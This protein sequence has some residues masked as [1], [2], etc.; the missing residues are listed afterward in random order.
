MKMNKVI[1]IGNLSKDPELSTTTSGISVCKFDIAVQRRFETN[2][3]R[4]TD[5]FKIIAWRGL[6]DNCAKYLHKGDKCAIVGSIQ[7]RSYEDKNGK[8]HYVTE[9]I[10]DEVEFL[11]TRKEE[12]NEPKL[13][14]APEE[15]QDELP[16]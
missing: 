9:I 1:L 5:F 10:A 14:P 2:G 13:S 8:K 16:F 15:I 3:E 11:S 12:R 4:E 6:A 7:N